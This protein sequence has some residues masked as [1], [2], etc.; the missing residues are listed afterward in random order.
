MAAFVVEVGFVFVLVPHRPVGWAGRCG[1]KTKKYKNKKPTSTTTCEF[2]NSGDIRRRSRVFFVSFQSRTDPLGG[3]VGVGLKQKR[4]KTKNRL[5]RRLVNCATV[6]VSVVEVG[7]FCFSP[8]PTRWMVW[9]VWIQNIK[10]Q[11]PKPTSP[12]TCEC[13]HCGGT[14]RKW[15]NQTWIEIL[16]CV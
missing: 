4:R 11:K 8:A 9:S 10:E 6:A 3:L 1:S 16:V 7:F 14:D 15:L 12:T 5:L 13:R 2:R